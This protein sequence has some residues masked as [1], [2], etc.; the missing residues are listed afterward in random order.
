MVQTHHSAWHTESLALISS[1]AVRIYTL[2]DILR[3]VKIFDAM[4]L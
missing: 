2:V 3:D 1:H 4:A